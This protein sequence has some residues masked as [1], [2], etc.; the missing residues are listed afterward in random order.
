MT[1]I[2]IGIGLAASEVPVPSAAAALRVIVQAE[3]GKLAS[4]EAAVV[5]A[6]GS[7]GRELAI[8][9]GFAAKLPA[10]GL[11]R[12]ANSPAIHAVTPNGTVTLA[13]TSF[14]ATKDLGSLYETAQLMIGAGAWWKAGYT[15]K[16][17]DVALID[18]GVVAVEGLKTP[19]KILNGPDLSPESQ[20]TNLRYLDTYG[21]GT[22]MAGIIAGRDSNVTSISAGD[23]THFL[24]VAPNA[25][26]VS[27]KVAESNGW[28]DVSQVIAGIDWVVQHRADPG[29]NI[30]VLNLSFGTD[31]TQTYVLD[32]LA[33]AVEVAWKRG[34]VV[35]VS[36]GN[37]GY[38]SAS[39]NNP[40]T[41]PFVIAVGASQPN[42]TTAVADDTVASFSS[43]GDGLRNPDI[44]APGKSIVSLRD[45]N[46]YADLAYPTARVGGR[47][48]RGSGT[49]Q[50]AAFVSG[51]AALIISGRPSITPDQVKRLL[52]NTARRLPNDKTSGQGAGLIDLVAANAAA[53]PLALTSTQVAVP[54]TGLGSLESARGTH[55][56]L[57]N[58]VSLVGEQDIFGKPLLTKVWAP[59][60]DALK[61]WS[62]GTWN[63]SSWS[64]SSWSGSSWSGS[65]W[66]GSSWSGS[67]WS[68]SSW[69]GNSW[70]GS[71]WSG[72]S[73]SGSSW[74]G[75]S[76]SSA[77][78][79]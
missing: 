16:G 25:R 11:P 31:A 40:A 48:F 79:N 6:G 46:S 38:G 51:A 10:T 64:G 73:W 12:L 54:S 71:S 20:R 28:T 42:G 59:L 58:G 72:S 34:I 65:S 60:A 36:A 19:G 32:P 26:I 17:V 45:P 35:V 29:L 57:M 7:V 66:S 41:N 77:G 33:H 27:V 21:H 14:D 68:G 69:S 22:H 43:K 1:A 67:S 4:A 23:S 74:S 50:A 9:D 5:A 75:N 37:E 30:R 3:P 62:G 53:T 70:S 76:W 49:S 56:L 78:W 8:I 2:S 44:V 18:S 61:S 63:G 47:F 55:H 52:I 24:G 39:M 15:G 13:A